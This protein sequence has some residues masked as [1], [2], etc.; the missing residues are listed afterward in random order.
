MASR[1]FL[2]CSLLLLTACGGKPEPVT[3]DQVKS[4]QVTMETACRSK[5]EADTRVDKALAAPFCACVMAAY[6]KEV[7]PA[8]WEA[9]YRAAATGRSAEELKVFQPYESRMQACADQ[10]LKSAGKG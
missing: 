5:A 10:V 6:R 3:A 7:Q 9:A 4:Y 1:C 8:E 2:A